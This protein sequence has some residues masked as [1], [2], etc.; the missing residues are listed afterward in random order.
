MSREDL[1]PPHD[2]LSRI[3]LCLVRVCLRVFLSLV[4]NVRFETLE[5][6]GKAV[7]A[8][9]RISLA[10]SVGWKF[11]EN[12]VVAERAVIESF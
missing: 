8:V 7:A 6:V 5:N 11:E 9:R 10:W 1:I 2:T 4:N 3:F 12:R